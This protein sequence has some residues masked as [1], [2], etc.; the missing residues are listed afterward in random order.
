MKSLLIVLLSFLLINC[1]NKNAKKHIEPDKNKQTESVD[2]I[3]KG[4]LPN[5]VLEL[6]SV[7]KSVVMFH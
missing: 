1:N 2:S 7:K 4:T 3:V 5:K 6:I